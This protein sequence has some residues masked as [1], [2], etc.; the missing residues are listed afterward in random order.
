MEVALPGR[1]VLPGDAFEALTEFLL[2]CCRGRDEGTAAGFS[3]QDAGLPAPREEKPEEQHRQAPEAPSGNFVLPILVPE[4]AAADSTAI[5]IRGLAGL[6]PPAGSAADAGSARAVDGLLEQDSA[7]RETVSAGQRVPRQSSEAEENILSNASRWSDRERDRAPSGIPSAAVEFGEVGGPDKDTAATPGP[8]IDARGLGKE[9]PRLP[10]SH[11]ARQSEQHPKDVTEAGNAP[12]GAPGISLK[13]AAVSGLPTGDGRRNAWSDP[14]AGLLR[15]LVAGTPPE[16][17]SRQLRFAGEGLPQRRAARPGEEPQAADPR[18]PSPLSPVDSSRK[19]PDGREE[20]ANSLATGF[21]PEVR[22]L[23]EPDPHPGPGIGGEGRLPVQE[24]GGGSPAVPRTTGAPDAAALKEAPEIPATPSPVEIPEYA[25]ES[26]WRR[27][28]LQ[29]DGRE[30]QR[31][32]IR[33]VQTP[34]SL[35]V[36]LSS[37]EASLVERMRSE[38]HQLE[39]SLEAAGWRTEIGVVTESE[40]APLSAAELRPLRTDQTPAAGRESAPDSG[41]H[42][43]ADSSADGRRSGARH[44]AELQEELIDLSAIRRLIKGGQQAP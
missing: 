11:P 44:A 41:P 15:S 42:S 1:P 43:G 17:S 2:S 6:V 21:Q 36:K 22:T 32:D 4:A 30:G 39:R 38:M 40:P 35:K 31:V 8:G 12:H 26:G 24:S 37:L 27:L 20:T 10:G 18:Q 29:V 13:W 7:P 16:G 33:L 9:L 19:K 28:V 23:P 5:P 3:S 14:G 34:G 25:P